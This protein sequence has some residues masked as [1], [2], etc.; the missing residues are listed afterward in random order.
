[1]LSKGW[2]KILAVMKETKREI[3]KGYYKKRNI[4]MDIILPI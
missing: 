2:L 3:R 1:M 4:S